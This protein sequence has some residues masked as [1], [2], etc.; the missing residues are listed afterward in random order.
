MIEAIDGIVSLDPFVVRR[1]ISFQDCDPAGVVF[2]GNYYDF[3]LWGYDLYANF[4]FQAK[5]LK[6]SAAMKAASFVHHAPLWPGD[7]LE[8]CIYPLSV[9]KVTHTLA[10]RAVCENRPIFNAD[11][12][13]ICRQEDE[14]K[15]CPIPVAIRDELIRD[16]AIDEL[17]QSKE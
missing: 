7:I 1:R 11:I 9:R 15:S 3:V 12:T 8:M 5:G 13:L 10:V 14:W 17:H 6:I 2:A 16:G 4:R